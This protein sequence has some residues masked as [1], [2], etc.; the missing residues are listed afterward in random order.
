MLD[1]D[2]KDTIFDS[3]DAFSGNYLKASNVKSEDESYL[4]TGLETIDDENRKR[5][6]L[7][8]ERNERKWKFDCNVTNTEKLMSVAVK[9]NELIDASIRFKK[10]FV[11]NPSTNKEVESLRISEIV[12]KKLQD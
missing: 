5:L 10:V 11:R 4:I 12:L 2:K 6:S 8:L 7:D 3:W 1:F 9:P